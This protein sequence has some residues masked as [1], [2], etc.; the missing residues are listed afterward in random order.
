M[1]EF[2]GIW[3]PYEILTDT[4][5]NDKEKII[6]SMILALSKENECIMSNAY[7]S[8]LLDITKIQASRIVNSLEKK[9]YIKIQMI[10][11]ENSKEIALR[12]IT[13]INKYVNTDKQICNNPI[14]KNVKDIININKIN[15]KKKSKYKSD[16]DYSDFNWT[17]LYANNLFIEKT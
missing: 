3:I 1:K 11:K 13:P 9:G 4:K 16:R 2:K 6:Y 14:N 15:H 10:Y 12:K 8:K 17:S 5:L 7:I